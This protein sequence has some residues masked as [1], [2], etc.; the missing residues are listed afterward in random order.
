MNRNK[1]IAIITLV[2]LNCIVLIGQAWPEG[3]PPFA[4]TVN[5]VFLVFSL[6]FFLNL[7]RVKSKG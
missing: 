7:L 4:R 5:I 2:I 3:A 1:K 6:L